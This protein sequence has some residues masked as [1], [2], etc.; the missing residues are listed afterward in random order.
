MTWV[1]LNFTIPSGGGRKRVIAEPADPINFLHMLWGY[2]REPPRAIVVDSGHNA[3]SRGRYIETGCSPATKGCGLV[4]G[5]V[6]RN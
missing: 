5:K 1:R 3:M 6:S 2:C 4:T